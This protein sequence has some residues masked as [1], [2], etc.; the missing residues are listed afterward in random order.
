MVFDRKPETSKIK[1]NFNESFSARSR[2]R[3]VPDTP[4]GPIATTVAITRASVSE[5]EHER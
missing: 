2:P 4:E 1:K 5:T 3:G